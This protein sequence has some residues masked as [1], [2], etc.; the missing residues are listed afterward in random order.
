MS[1]PI[2]PKPTEEAILEQDRSALNDGEVPEEIA[3]RSLSQIAWAR[4]KRD[5]MGMFSLWSVI[6]IV[7]VV[8]VVPFILTAVMENPLQTN[9]KLLDPATG[10]LPTGFLNSGISLRHPLGIEPGTGR[11][12]MLMLLYGARISLLVAGTATL[13]TVVIGVIIGTV[14]GY[15]G[16]WTDSTLSR[17]MDFILVFPLLIMLLALQPPLVQRLEAMGVPEGNPARVTYMILVFGIF[18][19][20]YL[21]RIIRG[22]VLSL[23][24]REFVESA[25]AMGSSGRRIVFKELIPNLWAPILVYATLTLPAYIAFEAALAFLGVGVAP[26]VT[27]WGKML[28][29]S[30][31]Y[32]TVTPTYLF[33][34]GGLLFFVVLVFNQLGDSVRDALDPRAG[35]V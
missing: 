27:T 5:R 16:G 32:V 14:S 28:A 26:P 31:T 19:W 12:I 25:V 7:V 35:R 11:D 10:S 1:S 8:T 21:A 13:F 24:E 2:I 9:V 6:S 34:P 20:P 33:I 29:E 15:V 22:Q 4:L 17:V 23:R 30:V 18:G 3:G